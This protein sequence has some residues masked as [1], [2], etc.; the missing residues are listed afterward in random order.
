MSA[1]ERASEAS[2]AEQANEWEVQ[3]NAS[4]TYS[5]STHC[6]LWN[7]VADMRVE[8][9]GGVAA[10]DVSLNADCNDMYYIDHEYIC[11]SF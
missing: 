2:S 7:G 4:I 5:H 1:A 6:G 9:G 10:R 8:E 3:G 11:K